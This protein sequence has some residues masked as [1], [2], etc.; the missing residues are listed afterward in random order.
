L[1]GSPIPASKRFLTKALRSDFVIR[2]RRLAS[3]IGV[4]NVAATFLILTSRGL[5]CFPAYDYG[6]AMNPS[7]FYDLH[8]MTEELVEPEILL[9][10]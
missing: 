9:T 3:S 10:D 7:G 6:V 4:P 1:I 8:N 2:I 5:S